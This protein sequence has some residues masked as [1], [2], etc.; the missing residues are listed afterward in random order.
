[1]AQLDD[2]IENSLKRKKRRIITAIGVS[3]ITVLLVG[4]VY[5]VSVVFFNDAETSEVNIE[6]SQDSILTS[7]PISSPPAQ[8]SETRSVL[9]Q[10]LSQLDEKVQLAL[11][12]P[13]MANWN[14]LA[15]EQISQKL[16]QAF[17]E[18][19]G[20]DYT[21]ATKT[22]DEVASQ[23]A[24][25]QQQYQA[26]YEQPFEQAQA[27]FKADNIEDASIFNNQSL[28]AN[29]DYA[30]AQA[31]Q[32][33]I[34][35][36]ADVTRW[37]SQL[38]IAEAEQNRNKQYNALKQIVN[39][40]PMRLEEQQ[41]LSAIEQEIK[42]DAFSEALASSITLLEN[43]ELTAAQN[44]LVKAQQ[45]DPTRT[46]LKTVQAKLAAAAKLQGVL[47]AEQ[48][49][50]VFVDADEWPTVKMLATSALQSHP[51]SEKL[52]Q[53]LQTAN[54]V[55]AAD[56][57]LERYLAR[58]TRLADNNIRGRA[59]AAINQY[60]WI[61]QISPKFAQRVEQLKQHLAQENKPLQ[62]TIISD[63]KTDIKV[64]GVGNVGKVKSKV[65]ELKPGSYKLEGRCKGFR[66][67]IKP[68]VVE[69]SDSPIEIE[70]VC[71]ER[72]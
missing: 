2:T 5:A 8:T 53:T 28:T 17:A 64:M 63:N 12:H 41:K 23:L 44:T 14:K 1:M 70:L 60:E 16:Q 66:T 18:Y 58:P 33:R 72:I 51:D 59:N 40:D 35:A 21:Q 38:R 25:L 67:Q 31:L 71:V 62:V 3:V 68:L 49:V 11:Q 27:A 69:R 24:A 48:Q 42:N 4:G 13:Y 55:V 15:S 9:Q 20:G 65:I 47:A 52:Q 6:Q 32:Q 57:H 46:E 34:D 30:P 56:A 61:T 36:F 50:T 26:A 22:L 37:L 43:G 19:A 10:R 54:E 45:I 29:P 39:L 7:S